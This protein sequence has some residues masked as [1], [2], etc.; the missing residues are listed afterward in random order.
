MGMPGRAASQARAARKDLCDRLV[1]AARVGVGDAHGLV[2]GTDQAGHLLRCGITMVRQQP[3]R[4]GP[5]RRMGSVLFGQGAGDERRGKPLDCVISI[6]R[7]R[8]SP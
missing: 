5:M 8:R 7:H 2:V 1:I 3:E 4:Y 6:A